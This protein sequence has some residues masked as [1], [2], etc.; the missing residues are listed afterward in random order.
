MFCR[1]DD[2]LALV[3]TPAGDGARDVPGEDG[4]LTLVPGAEAYQTR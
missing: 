4:E 1:D 2:T 3:L